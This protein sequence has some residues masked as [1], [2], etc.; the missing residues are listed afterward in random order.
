MSGVEEG[1]TIH[2]ISLYVCG[3][4]LRLTR[5]DAAAVIPDASAIER[6]DAASTASAGG[7]SAGGGSEKALPA[8]KERSKS[9]DMGKRMGG[10]QKGV[11]GN[12]GE[13]LTTVPADEHDPSFDSETEDNAVLVSGE[14]VAPIAAAKVIDLDTLP[15]ELTVNPPAEIKKRVAEIID[16]YL[17]SGDADE[18]RRCV[19]SVDDG[20]QPCL[21]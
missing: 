7:S 14:K 19:A 16:E 4:V 1:A 17:T 15:D 9:R 18:V 12:P 20:R 3:L 6:D 13:I 21:Y 11:W 10:G 5:L 8:R 2:Q